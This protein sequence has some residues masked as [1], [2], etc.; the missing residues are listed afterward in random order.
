MVKKINIPLVILAGGRGTRISE[1]TK[2]IPKPMI[3]IG[4]IPIIQHIIDYYKSF[5]VENIYIASGYK[6]HIIRKYFHKNK[7]ITVIDTGLKTLT[8]GRIKRLENIIDG[9]FFLT[10]GDGLSNVNITYLI[11]SHEKSNKIATVTAV[12]PVARFGEIKLKNNLPISFNEKPQVKN[13]WINGGFFIFE[14]SIFQYLKNDN[15]VLETSPMHKLVN[16]NQLNV[17]KHQ[18]F[19]QCMDTVRDKELLD[20]IYKSNFCPW[21]KKS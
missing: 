7:N 18:G 6:S 5:G 3:K 15:T 20:K 16:D 19:W 21:K 11:K 12:H 17:Y 2:I 14:Q 1:Y 4:R 9:K 13:D 8:G 10:Y